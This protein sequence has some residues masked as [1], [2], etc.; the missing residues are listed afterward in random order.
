[1]NGLMKRLL[2][3][4]AVISSALAAPLAQDAPP[5]DDPVATFVRAQM[6]WRLIPG[7]AIAVIQ[8]GQLRRAQGFGVAD[9]ERNSRITP[10]TVFHTGS[11]GKPFTAIAILKLVE[12]RRIQLDDPILKFF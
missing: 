10:E 12:Q 6:D 3:A 1:M 8:N 2:I 11:I 9:A 4:T 7:V 5:A